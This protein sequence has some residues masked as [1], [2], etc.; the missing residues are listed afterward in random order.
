[1]NTRY[2]I[3]PAEGCDPNDKEAYLHITYLSLRLDNLKSWASRSSNL[4]QNIRELDARV[5]A[6]VKPYLDISTHAKL[7]LPISQSRRLKI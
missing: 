3:A 7:T 1:M 6:Y 2:F 5:N 4:R